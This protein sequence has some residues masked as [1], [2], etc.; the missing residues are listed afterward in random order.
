MLLSHAKIEI[1][2]Q[3]GRL[4][5]RE[6]PIP[7]VDL[8][9]PGYKVLGPVGIERIEMFLDQEIWDTRCELEADGRG[10]RTSTLMRSNP[11]PVSLCQVSDGQSIGDPSKGHRLR[12][13]D[14]DSPSHSQREE[15]RDGVEHFS[16]S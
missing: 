2:S 3:P 8:W 14:I 11:A 6:M 15:L 9:V 1:E 5:Q 13:P 16:R 4:R 12:L 10:H 7:R